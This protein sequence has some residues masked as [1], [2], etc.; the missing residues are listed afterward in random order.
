MLEI[1]RFLLAITTACNLKC[2]Y[3]FVK[4]T[5]EF[6]SIEKAKKWILFFLNS[7]GKDKLLYL[8]GGEPL[9][10]F[11]FIKKI[12]PFF[13]QSA[14]KIN[15]RA[16]IIIVTNG[17]IF[18]KKIGELIKKYQL[19]I[20]ISLSGQ[21]KSHDLFRHFK[22]GKGTFN[23]IGKNLKKFLKV[24]STENLWV[25]YTL[26]PKMLKNFHSDLFYLINLGFENLHIEP[27]QYTLRVY[28]T[29]NEIRKFSQVIK[30]FFSYLEEKINQNQFLFISKLIRNLEISLKI[31]P[32]NEFYY[33]IYNNLRVW[34][35]SKLTFCHFAP[36]ILKKQL[37]RKKLFE[38]VILENGEKMNLKKLQRIFLALKEIETKGPRYFSAGEK[39]WKVYNQLCEELAQK[40]ILKSQKN[41]LYKEYIKKALER[42]I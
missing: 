12:V 6:I 8:Y 37:S 7:A 42:A 41:K 32:K 13:Y 26:H 36:N 20:M 22:N 34:P 40:I 15:K 29:N 3:C 10:Y 18:N 38:K 27:V 39:I 35:P 21:K 28:W 11:D 5:Q 17:T 9:I 2:D 25:S 1:R 24:V 23:M 33:N 4:D 31:A 30:N 16:S 14:R 19:K